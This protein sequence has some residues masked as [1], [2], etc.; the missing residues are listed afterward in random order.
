MCIIVVKAS[1]RVMPHKN[2]LRNC[3]ENNDDGAGYAFQRH[4]EDIIHVKKGFMK[5][6]HFWKAINKLDVKD[7]DR[8]IMHFRIGTSGM[9]N[10]RMCHPFVVGEEPEKYGIIDGKTKG[11]VVAHNGIISDLSGGKKL[12]DTALL[13]KNILSSK[14]VQKGLYE[15]LA[16]QELIETFICSGRLAFIHPAKGVLLLGDGWLKAKSGVYYSN[17]GYKKKTY[18]FKGGWDGLSKRGSARSS[19]G[20]NYGNHLNGYDYESHDYHANKSRTD[21]NEKLAENLKDNDTTYSDYCEGCGNYDSLEWSVPYSAMLCD[22]C[23]KVVDKET[24]EGALIKHY[25]TTEK[26]DDPVLTKLKEIA[27]GKK[28]DKK[29]DDEEETKEYDGNK[30]L[31]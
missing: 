21:D 2:T 4:G 27:E 8:I 19:I 29:E 11:L 26:K 7:K 28:E 18:V 14:I 16:V 17:T 12:S 30:N 1:G 23:L 3:F 15:D 20:Y 10:A 24:K 31:K 13:V 6:K 9:M 22:T 5:F 25:N